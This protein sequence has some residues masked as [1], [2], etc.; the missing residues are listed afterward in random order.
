MVQRLLA[1]ARPLEPTAF[2]PLYFLVALR[3]SVATGMELEAL[4]GFVVRRSRVGG[5]QATVCEMIYALLKP[6]AI[7]NG[8][9]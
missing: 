2:S 4:H 1:W 6:H 8:G 9:S 7:Q 5:L 3:R